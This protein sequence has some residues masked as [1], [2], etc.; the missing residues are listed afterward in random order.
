[1]LSITENLE[2]KISD[3]I[4]RNFDCYIFYNKLL[5]LKA[6]YNVVYI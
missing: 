3:K 2:Y 1:M 6:K 5:I 4:L